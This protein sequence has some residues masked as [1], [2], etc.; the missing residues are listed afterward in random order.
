MVSLETDQATL[1]VAL[2]DWQPTPSGRQHTLVVMVGPRQR[3]TTQAVVVVQRGQLRQGK[4]VVMVL[5]RLQVRPV[6]GAVV[7]LVAHHQRLVVRELRLL[8]VKAAQAL[9]E[10][11][12][13]REQLRLL[14]LAQARMV[15]VAAVVSDLLT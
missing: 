2:V 11:Q 10:Q 13:V 1:Q 7:V 5:G 14:L 4:T 3:Q 15:P 6:Q 12:A 8:A 9:L